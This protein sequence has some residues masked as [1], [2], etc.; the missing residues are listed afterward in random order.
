M[1]TPGTEEVFLTEIPL[2]FPLRNKDSIIFNHMDMIVTLH[3]VGDNQARV[4]GFHAEPMSV[5]EG[6]DREACIPDY[7]NLHVVREG[8]PFRF[9]YSIRTEYSE[10]TWAHRLDHYMKLGKPIIHWTQISITLGIILLTSFTTVQV[11]LSALH[12]DSKAI[13]WWMLKGPGS[14]RLQY[15]RANQEEEAD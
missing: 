8:D 10:L 9:S 1:A 15:K 6:M 3:K 5:S 12:K 14:R 13:K 2:G 4:V 11:I 7:T